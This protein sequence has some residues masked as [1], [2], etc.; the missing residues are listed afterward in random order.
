MISSLLNIVIVLL[1]ISTVTLNSLLAG[2]ER[3]TRAAEVSFTW[4]KN[5]KTRVHLV[6]NWNLL[7][8]YEAVQN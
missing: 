7:S 8:E 3:A 6:N 5:V 2:A 1:P 4:K